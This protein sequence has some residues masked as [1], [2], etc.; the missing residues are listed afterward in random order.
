[1][2]KPMSSWD[3]RFMALGFRIRDLFRPRIDVLREAGIRAGS[4][5]LDYGCGPG[6]YIPALAELVGPSG[7]IYALDVNPLAIKMTRR[8]AT[9]K[10]VANLEA[11][12]SDRDTGLPDESVDAVLLYDTFHDLSLPDDVLQELHR[13]L[14]ADG[15][16]SFSDHH[17]EEEGIIAAITGSGLF[18]L[19]RQDKKTHTFAKAGAEAGRRG[20]AVT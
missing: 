16:L 6:G 12:V 10:R 19:A 15:I 13:V 20:T 1:M 2:D 3:F 9:R 11:V 14:R 4:H 17:M 7:K 8:L 18:E 5:V